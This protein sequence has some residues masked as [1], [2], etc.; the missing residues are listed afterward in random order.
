MITAAVAVVVAAA[1]AAAAAGKPSS[2]LEAGGAEVFASPV[3]R[4]FVFGSS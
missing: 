2:C 1:A 3:F 4:V